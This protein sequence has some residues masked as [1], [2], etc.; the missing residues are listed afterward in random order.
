MI[1]QV[2]RLNSTTYRTAWTVSVFSSSETGR[3]KNS[4]MIIT[5]LNHIKETTIENKII[6]SGCSVPDCSGMG[7]GHAAAGQGAVQ[8]TGPVLC[9]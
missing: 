1:A 9:Q 5:L 8:E 2:Y 4:D 6:I 3:K 7:S